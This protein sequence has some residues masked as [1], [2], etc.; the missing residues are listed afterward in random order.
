MSKLSQEIAGGLD[1]IYDAAGDTVV[2]TDRDG[3]ETTVTA[4]MVYDLLTYGEVADITALTASISVRKSELEY[5]PRRGETYKLGYKVYTV[6][7]VITEDDL[8]H[9]ALVA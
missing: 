4:I 7:Q 8:E 6:D 2:F 1:E 3:V 9:T 5:A